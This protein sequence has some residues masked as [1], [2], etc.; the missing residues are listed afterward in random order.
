MTRTLQSVFQSVFQRV[1]P[2]WKTN[3]T[4]QIP[5]SSNLV[6]IHEEKKKKKRRLK[7]FKSSEGDLKN[8]EQFSVSKNVQKGVEGKNLQESKALL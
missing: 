6:M 3:F 8:S 4:F 5:I 1:F 2:A 7:F